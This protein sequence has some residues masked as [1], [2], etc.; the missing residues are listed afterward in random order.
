MVIKNQKKIFL[1]IVAII[2]V[3]LAALIYFYYLGKKPVNNQLLVSD[4]NAG[5]LSGEELNISESGKDLLK[6]LKILKS[7]KL[8]TSFF[9]QDAFKGLIDFSKDLPFEESGRSNPFSPIGM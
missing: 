9:D 4:I 1:M 5:L 2:A 8:D 7:V 6:S 3:V